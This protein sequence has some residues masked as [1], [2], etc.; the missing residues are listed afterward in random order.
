VDDL[1]IA[2]VND[3]ALI[4]FQKKIRSTS[5]VKIQNGNE[6]DYSG[7]HL[8][9]RED[10]IVLSQ[11]SMVRELVKDVLGTANSPAADDD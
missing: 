7:I 10:V 1:L 2:A 9:I 11:L 6:L 3:E 8:Q 4:E 5:K